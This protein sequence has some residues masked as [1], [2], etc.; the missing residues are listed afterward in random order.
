MWLAEERKTREG[1]ECFKLKHRDAIVL[2][3]SMGGTILDWKYKGEDILFPRQVIKIDSQ[4]KIRGGSHL[5]FPFFGPTPEGFGAWP[6][7]GNMRDELL[8]IVSFAENKIVFLMPEEQ[9]GFLPNRVFANVA[10]ELFD[11]GDA[12]F[13][14]HT[15]WAG[16]LYDKEEEQVPLNPGFHPYLNSPLGGF[17]EMGYDEIEFSGPFL[18]TLENTE[19]RKNF[20]VTLNKLGKVLISHKINNKNPAEI[21]NIW[22]DRGGYICFE[23]VL[24]EREKFNTPEGFFL[25]PGEQLTSSCQFMF[26]PE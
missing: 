10:V 19:G 18:L 24:K 23:P 26:T 11:R 2:A 1:E 5:C 25:G 12:C 8:Q 22:S 3:S 7:H 21:I 13:L 4:E 20:K 9:T 14:N 6:Q 16:R 15:L 17:A